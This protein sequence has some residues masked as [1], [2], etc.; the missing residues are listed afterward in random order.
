MKKYLVVFI[1]FVSLLL[2]GCSNNQENTT[3]TNNI[4]LGKEQ[5]IKQLKKVNIDNTKDYIMVTSKVSWE[6]E[7]YEDGTTVSYSI[8]V[9][10]LIHV[11]G[12]N[13]T[14]SYI[15][16]DDIEKNDDGNPKYDVTIS[17]VNNS[18]ETRVL[19]T[20]K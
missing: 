15:L 3:N 5:Y 2:V 16:G 19:I 11:D 6:P 9:P 7:E 14:G 12:K 13:Y 20:K 8:I 10:Y 1:C 17:D 18:Y 4:E